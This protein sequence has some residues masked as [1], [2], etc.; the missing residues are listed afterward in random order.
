MIWKLYFTNN[1][2]FLQSKCNLRFQGAAIRNN[3]LRCHKDGEPY[4]YNRS[5]DQFIPSILVLMSFTTFRTN[6]ADVQRR[7]SILLLFVSVWLVRKQ[8]FLSR[9]FRTMVNL[10]P[11]IYLLVCLWNIYRCKCSF[12]FNCNC[13]VYFRNSNFNRFNFIDISRIWRKN[14]TGLENTLENNIFRNK[15]ILFG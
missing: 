12:V 10:I 6:I 11:A 13:I 9:C 2:L 4:W 3:I 7:F 8:L 15:F 1:L 5:F 14:D